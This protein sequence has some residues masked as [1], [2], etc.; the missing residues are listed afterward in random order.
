MEEI[1]LSDFYADEKSRS[2]SIDKL[3]LWLMPFV[4]FAFLGF[5]TRY[6]GYVTILSNFAAPAFFVLC[7]FLN[8]V[9]DSEVRLKK[10]QKALKHSLML[11][12][13]ML[14]SYIAINILYLAYCDALNASIAAEIFRKRVAFN[15]L[16]LNVWVPLPMGSSIWFIH[17]LFYAYVFFLLAERLKLTK[18][19]TPLLIILLAVMLATGEFAAFLKFPHFGYSYIPAGAVTRAIPY[20]LIGMLIRKHIDKLGKVSRFVYLALFAL[21]LGLA[22]AE[23]EILNRLGLLIYRGHAIG[24]GIAAIAICC[25]AFV[26]P[27]VSE[28]DFYSNHSRNYA[29]R[30]YILCQPVSL[31]VYIV[32]PFIYP[33]FILYYRQYDGI[34]SL[35]ICF[36]ISLVIGTAK[37]TMLISNYLKK[38]SK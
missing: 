17:S 38:K 6:G 36:I 24:L 14:L 9:P 20:M 1:K 3:K 8:L 11:F 37:H 35:L 22:F 5:P 7:G 2:V 34:I 31:F 28:R 30:L 16:V 4:F 13:I 26:N 12:L 19:Y 25:F 32:G 33:M 29:R 21:G 27:V 23:F 15:F 10:V 18:L